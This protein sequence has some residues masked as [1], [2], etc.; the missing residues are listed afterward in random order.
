MRSV[1]VLLAVLS[2]PS[3]ALASRVLVLPVGGELGRSEGEALS[4][5][6]ETAVR[7]ATAGHEVMTL[8]AL[9]TSMR[10]SELRDCA[11]DEQATACVSEIADAANA[12]VVVA[13]TLGRLGDQLLLTL[14][15]TA[16]ARATLLAQVQRRAD[17]DRPSALLDVIPGAVR[18]AV[19]DAGLVNAVPRP[20]PVAAIGTAVGGGVLAA[21]GTVALVVRGVASGQYAE[22]RLDQEQARAY[23]L[24]DQPALFGG[25]I[26]VVVG[27]AFTIGGG[28]VAV[29]SLVARE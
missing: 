18:Q 7:E 26:G 5:A 29:Y 15:L 17:A 21:L 22:G 10:M 2:A 27:G 6:V 24:Y 3:G 12:D 14:T 8:A 4:R 9:Q 13:P 28:G 19:D 11:G 20:V 1:L 23:E 25:V 16:G